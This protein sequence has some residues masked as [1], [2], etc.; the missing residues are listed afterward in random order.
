MGKILSLTAEQNHPLEAASALLQRICL[1][2]WLLLYLYLWKL[3]CRLYFG[4]LLTCRRL[5]CYRKATEDYVTNFFCAGMY[6]RKFL[7]TCKE[8]CSYLGVW[9]SRPSSAF[10]LTLALKKLF[11]TCISASQ[12]WNGNCKGNYSCPVL[13]SYSAAEL[14]S[15]WKSLSSN[16]VLHF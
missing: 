8:S 11:N 4:E 12:L 16:K 9:E 2:K 6:L 10:S 15:I 5:V 14:V 1:A 7:I 3:I 13:Q